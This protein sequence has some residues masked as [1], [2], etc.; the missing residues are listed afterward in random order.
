MNEAMSDD[1]YQDKYGKNMMKENEE[2]AKGQN[3]WK[4]VF[5]AI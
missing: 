1:F 4:N 3:K 5:D 2:N